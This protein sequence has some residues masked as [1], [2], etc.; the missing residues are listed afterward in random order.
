MT[1]NKF[2]VGDRVVGTNRGYHRRIGALGVVHKVDSDGYWV[3][4]DSGDIVFSEHDAITHYGPTLEELNV[5]AGDVVECV[6]MGVDRYCYPIDM[7][8]TIS[9]RGSWCGMYPNLCK[10]LFR[11]ISRAADK[12]TVCEA[13]YTEQDNHEVSYHMGVPVAWREVADKI[14][15]CEEPCVIGG[16]AYIA[17]GKTLNGKPVGQWII[18]MDEQE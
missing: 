10:G 5:K 11:I 8:R 6:K 16:E 17:K 3:N 7:T 15:T 13:D 9:E 1:Q 2:K 14:M 18:N 4:W 12:W